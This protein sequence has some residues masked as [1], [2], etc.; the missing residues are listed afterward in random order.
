MLLLLYLKSHHWTQDHINFLL[1]YALE[2]LWVSIYVLIYGPLGVNFHERCTVRVYI[3]FHMSVHFLHNHLLKTILS[4]WICLCSFVQNW[5]IL[6]ILFHWSTFLFPCHYQTIL[7]IAVYSKSVSQM[8]PVLEVCPSFSV[9]CYLVLFNW[10]FAFLCKI[11]NQF[12]DVSEK[13]CWDFD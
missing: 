9:L 10:V 4:P 6:S 7:I 2:V 13:V 11:E 12:V 3:F 1:W 8:A 5:T